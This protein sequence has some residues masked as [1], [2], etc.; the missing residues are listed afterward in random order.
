MGFGV[1]LRHW[2]QG[3]L[4]ATLRDVLL[5]PRALER[6]YFR[7]AVLEQLVDDH[8]AGRADYQNALF[9]LTMLELWHRLTIDPPQGGPL[10]VP[11]AH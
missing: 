2:F 7:P 5:S 8:V 4:E 6:G 11:A 10:P 3:G 1:P 9:N